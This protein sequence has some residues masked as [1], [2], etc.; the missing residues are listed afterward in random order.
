MSTLFTYLFSPLLS[1]HQSISLLSTK[2]IIFWTL[3]VL[4]T[5]TFYKQILCLIVNCS[6]QQTASFILLLPNQQV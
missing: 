6:I 1:D 5:K 2:A 3:I 4:P